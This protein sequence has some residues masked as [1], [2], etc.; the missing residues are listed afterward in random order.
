MKDNLIVLLSRAHKIQNHSVSLISRTKR[1]VKNTNTLR[2]LKQR[3]LLIALLC[4]K[5]RLIRCSMVMI[6][7]PIA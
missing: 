5:L 2:V 1:R 3:T 6:P 4:V 7:S